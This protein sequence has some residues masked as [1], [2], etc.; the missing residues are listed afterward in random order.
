MNTLPLSGW[1]DIHR[2]STYGKCKSAHFPAQGEVHPA[3]VPFSPTITFGDE[4][5]LATLEAS[6][7]KSFFTGAKPTFGVNSSGGESNNSSYKRLIV[8]GNGAVKIAPSQVRMGEMEDQALRMMVAES[9]EESWA[10]GSFIHT[11]RSLVDGSFDISPEDWL[12]V[13]NDALSPTLSRSQ[14]LDSV[15]NRT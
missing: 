6:E 15:Y 5:Q 3:V 8:G 9:H 4:T 7:D 2:L 12:Q 14:A 10:G 1:G 13:A 11:N